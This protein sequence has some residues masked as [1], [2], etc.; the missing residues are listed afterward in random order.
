MGRDYGQG[1]DRHVG[2]L[3]DKCHEPRKADQI[4]EEPFDVIMVPV[5]NGQ[6]QPV[7]PIKLETEKAQALPVH[8]RPGIALRIIY[9]NIEDRIRNRQL[10]DISKRTLVSVD[11]LLHLRNQVR[12]R[13]RNLAALPSLAMNGPSELAVRMS[14]LGRKAD[15]RS[16]RPLFRRL[17]PLRP[18]ERTYRHSD[19][20]VCS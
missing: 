10:I 15:L 5:D 1:T 20:G 6:H 16:Q 18:R 19:R 7:F 9:Q 14:A 8:Y 11:V 13:I 17:R 4:A 12:L 3:S 2:F